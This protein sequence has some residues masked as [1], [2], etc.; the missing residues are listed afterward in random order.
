MAD[1]SQ[2]FPY[3]VWDITFAN[4]MLFDRQQADYHHRDLDD[5][6]VFQ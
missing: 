6:I 3:L 4:S 2:T 5:F 1:V